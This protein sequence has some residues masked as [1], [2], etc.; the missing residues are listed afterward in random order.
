MP[1]G[2]YTPFKPLDLIDV[3]VQPDPDD[4]GSKFDKRSSA[5]IQYLTI[6]E[7][8]PEAK[9]LLL[10][11]VLP[12][13]KE[14]ETSYD[15]RHHQEYQEYLRAQTSD[16]ITGLLEADI[17]AGIVDIS[18]SD[19]AAF[20]SY[21]LMTPELLDPDK[22]RFA[23]NAFVQGLRNPAQNVHT[24]VVLLHPYRRWL[25]HTNTA[26]S[27]TLEKPWDEKRVHQLGYLFAQ[28]IMM[29][30]LD[31]QPR[32]AALLSAERPSSARAIFTP[33]VVDFRGRYDTIVTFCFLGQRQYG[34]REIGTGW[35]LQ[36]RKCRNLLI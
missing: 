9:E 2:K 3:E 14:L 18:A 35:F 23:V 32:E 31:M 24:R 27:D 20:W 4:V 34:K 22:C 30:E 15:P 12:V 19:S 25:N 28:H 10:N 29:I 17:T 16:I 33:N 6:L 7:R 26:W 36:R 8:W 11:F 21:A 5:L 13:V 1:T